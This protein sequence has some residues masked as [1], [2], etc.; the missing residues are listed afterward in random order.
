[1]AEIDPVFAGIIISILGIAVTIVIGYWSFKRK[2]PKKQSEAKMIQNVKQEVHLHPSQRKENKK[3]KRSIKT[4][5]KN[6]YLI[7]EI[8]K[9]PSGSSKKVSFDLKQ[10]DVIKGIVD[11]ADKYEFNFYI[12]DETEYSNFRNDDDFNP[13]FEREDISSCSIKKTIPDDDKW[14]F[15]FDTYGK[16]YDRKIQ[17]QLRKVF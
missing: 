16:Q 10:G 3:L 14:Y 5:V 7:D 12:M 4:D 9:V 11:E 2:E 17:V 6:K 15:V 1:M 8:I 13:I